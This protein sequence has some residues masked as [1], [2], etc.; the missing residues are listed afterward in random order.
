M[1]HS[2]RPSSVIAISRISIVRTA[3]LAHS[4]NS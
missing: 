2:F 3:A 4:F 1:H